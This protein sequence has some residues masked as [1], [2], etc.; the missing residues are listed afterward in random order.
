MSVKEPQKVGKQQVVRLGVVRAGDTSTTVA[1]RLHTKDGSAT[2]GK[3][4]FAISKG[5]ALPE[6][7]GYGCILHF[8]VCFFILL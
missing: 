1:V 8:S 6:V 4:Y 2:A 7:L 3:D 5:E